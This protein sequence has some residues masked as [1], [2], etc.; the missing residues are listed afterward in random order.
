MNNEFFSTRKSPVTFAA[1]AFILGIFHKLV[2]MGLLVATV[3]AAIYTFFFL[4]ERMT[5]RFIFYSYLSLILLWLLSIALYI[6]YVTFATNMSLRELYTMWMAFAGAES[7]HYIAIAVASF[8]SLFLLYV[9]YKPFVRLGN[10]L[11]LHLLQST[12]H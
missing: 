7:L 3:P 9:I 1:L 6:S 2:L 4:K 10:W 8:I 5:N 12:S 11:G